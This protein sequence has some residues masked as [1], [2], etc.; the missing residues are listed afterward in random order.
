MHYSCLIITKEFPTNDVLE[1]A[2]APFHDDVVYKQPEESRV[3]PVFMWDYWQIG[4][5]YAGLFKL[6]VENEEK[7]KWHYYMNNPRN[8]RLF[9]SYLLDKMKGF[10]EESRK[11]NFMYKEEDYFTSMGF[12]DGFLYVDGAKV[13][14][15]INFSEVSCY[16]CIDQNGNAIARET[17][18]G[19]SWNV[20][21][22]F[23][24][25]MKNIIAN[26]RDWYACI[27]DIHD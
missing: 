15:I 25:K 7:Y 8:G 6:T 11:P 4:G 17:W 13:C 21:P 20:D 24:E 27:V 2:L 1:K 14:D 16:C 5:R 18:D 23:D 22:M 3:Y 12:L 9:R 19:N 10:A 26:S